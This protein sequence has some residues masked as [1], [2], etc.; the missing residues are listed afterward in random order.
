M[1]YCIMQ[2]FRALRVHPK[3]IHLVIF[4]FTCESLKSVNCD[5]A[6]CRSFPY[7]G[8]EERKAG[9]RAASSRGT[10][11]C[12][13]VSLICSISS[14]LWR[15]QVLLFIFFISC[16]SYWT[17]NSP[18]CWPAPTRSEGTQCWAGFKEIKRC[19]VGKAVDS[20]EES[21]VK[22][23][24]CT[25]SVWSLHILFETFQASVII[26]TQLWMISKSFYGES[27]WGWKNK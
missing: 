27:D 1:C 2:Q 9:V 5:L 3:F 18:L 25:A 4:M 14:A 6:I 20:Q 15:I 26:I 21:L 23:E 8:T 19:L 10:F 22:S 16:Y 24:H 17:F 13:T 11:H 12:S 7:R